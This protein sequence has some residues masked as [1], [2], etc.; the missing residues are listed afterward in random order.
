MKIQ[1]ILLWKKGNKNVPHNVLIYLAI[2]SDI[3]DYTCVYTG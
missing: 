3:V 2:N 1:Y